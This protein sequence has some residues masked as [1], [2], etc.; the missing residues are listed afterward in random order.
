M[1]G[2]KIAGR[3]AWIGAGLIAAATGAAAQEGMFMKDVLGTIGIIPKDQPPIE[4]RER[5]PLVVPPKLELRDPVAPN[6]VEARIPEWPK[7]P[8][9]IEARRK[10]AEAR[11]PITE[12]ERRRMNADSGARLSIDEIRAGRK[13]GAG[14]PT[15]PTYRPGDGGRADSWVHP[16]QLRAQGRKPE[17]LVPGPE[18]ERQLLSE[19]PSGFRR[20]AAGA[21]VRADSEPV[22]R[23][24]EAD[25]KAYHRQQQLRR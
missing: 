19:P 12:M 9:V 6:A 5:P 22:V 13:P 15:S 24:D 23:E 11:V 20:P 10:E 18:P 21:V 7:D 25:P 3:G 16:D 8:D 1:K 17:T 4:Y 14:I 2:L